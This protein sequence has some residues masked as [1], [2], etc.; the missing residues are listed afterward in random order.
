VFAAWPAAGVFV[1]WPGATVL[2]A[3]WTVA[4]GVPGRDV[5]AAEPA[6]EPVEAVPETAA[7]PTAPEEPVAPPAE[8]W[9]AAAWVAAAGLPG[10]PDLVVVALPTG[11]GGLETA[12]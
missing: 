3:P 8:A 12:S 7:V 9:V 5:G 6:A 11:V 1:G 10:V 2:A 4:P